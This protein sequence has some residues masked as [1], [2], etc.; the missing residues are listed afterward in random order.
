MVTEQPGPAQH[1]SPDLLQ[2]R[3]KS[4]PLCLW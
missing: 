4:Q 3:S 2:R 1:N